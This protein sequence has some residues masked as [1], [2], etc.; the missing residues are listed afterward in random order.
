MHLAAESGEFS[1]WR[2]GEA[3]RHLISV[4]DTFIATLK[5]FDAGEVDAIDCC[6][7]VA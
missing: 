1:V 5:V 6:A 3:E 7:S 4:R 2:V